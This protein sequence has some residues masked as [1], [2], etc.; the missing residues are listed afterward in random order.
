M[1][2]A[3]TGLANPTL[4]GDRIGQANARAE[5]GEPPPPVMLLDLDDFFQGD[6]RWSGARRG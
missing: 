1:I 4:L 6:Q 3:L 5:R 2:D